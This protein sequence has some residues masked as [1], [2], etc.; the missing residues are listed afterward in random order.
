MD[1]RFR[2]RMSG[3]KA[4]L[5]GLAHTEKGRELRCPCGRPYDLSTIFDETGLFFTCEHCHRVWEVVQVKIPTLEERLK[6]AEHRRT[7]R[8]FARKDSRG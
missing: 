3:K 7:P 1:T 5:P 4:E 2:R 8:R 6:A